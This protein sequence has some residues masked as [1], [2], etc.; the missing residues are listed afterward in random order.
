MMARA[1]LWLLAATIAL[2]PLLVPRGPGQSAPVDAAALLFVAFSLLGLLRRGR[3]LHLPAK[4]ALAL[5]VAASVVATVASL[6][7]SDS[8][9]SLLI[10]AYLILLFQCV[11]NELRGDRQALRVALIVWAVAA[12]AWAA[13]FIGFQY[14]LLPEGLQ[15]LLVENSNGRG[16][17]VSGASK[18]PNMAASYMM[19]SFFVLLASPWPRRRLAR[20]AAAGWLLLA[21]WVTGSNGALLG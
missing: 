11:A 7:L 5:I 6:S 20:V 10:E 8:L 3:P 17:R 14:H 21:T 19:T 16:Y 15:Q 12:L 2:L 13:V 4:G 9:L 18:N 1:N